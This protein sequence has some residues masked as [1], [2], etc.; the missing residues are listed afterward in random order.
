MVF[1]ISCSKSVD[2]QKIIEKI[3]P[4]NFLDKCEQYEWT[5]KPVA[6][7]ECYESWAPVF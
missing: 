4:S 1:L 5:L 7:M 2:K 6:C 3:L